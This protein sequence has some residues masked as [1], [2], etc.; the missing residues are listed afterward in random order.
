MQRPKT[1][2]AILQSKSSELKDH[3]I[4][5]SE[6]LLDDLSTDEPEMPKPEGLEAELRESLIDFEEVLATK[7]VVKGK[8]LADDKKR[9]EAQKELILRLKPVRT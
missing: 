4:D 6:L 9:M 5:S 3:K 1:A 2:S 8:T 7:I